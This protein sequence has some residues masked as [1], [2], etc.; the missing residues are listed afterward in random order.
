[1]QEGDGADAEAQELVGFAG[2]G[3]GGVGKVQG[4]GEAGDRA[5]AGGDEFFVFGFFCWWGGG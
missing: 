2:V 5:C 4:F 3:G 1:M